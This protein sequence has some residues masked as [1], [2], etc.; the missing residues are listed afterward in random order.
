MGTGDVFADMDCTLPWS[1]EREYTLTDCSGNA[2]SFSYTIDVNGM[3][4]DPI[5]PTLDG[6]SEDDSSWDD[7]AISDDVIGDEEDTADNKL[8]LLGLTPNPSSD[9]ALLTFMTSVNEMVSVN[10][11]NASGMLVM[12]LYQGQV[13]AEVPM[14]IEIPSNVLENGLY[15][16]QILSASGSISAKLMITE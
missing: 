7:G 16:L 9:F 4:C 6:N 3:T 1:V 14:N 5:D 8:K 12:N 2:S 15:Q 11:F 13:F 10:V